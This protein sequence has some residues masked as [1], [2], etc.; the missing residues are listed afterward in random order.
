MPPDRTPPWA[1][2]TLAEKYLKNAAYTKS[3]EGASAFGHCF[4]D[5]HIW[6]H[7]THQCFCRANASLLTKAQQQGLCGPLEEEEEVLEELLYLADTLLEEQVQVSKVRGRI[8]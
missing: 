7:D 4:G 8:E 5:S 2:A 3:S 1:N 6:V